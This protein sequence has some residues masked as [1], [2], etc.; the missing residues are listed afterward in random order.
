M[1]PRIRPR[2]LDSR[3]AG[4][5]PCVVD[6]IGEMTRQEVAMRHTYTARAVVAITVIL[7]AASVWFAVAT[8]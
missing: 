2:H 1:S 8:G 5:F 6:S 3:P 7:L 4:R